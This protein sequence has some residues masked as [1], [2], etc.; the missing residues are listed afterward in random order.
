ML[1]NS[2]RVAFLLAVI[3]TVSSCAPARGTLP[4]A[5]IIG[6]SASFSSAPKIVYWRNGA[7]QRELPYKD[8]AIARNDSAKMLMLANDAIVS[9][10]SGTVIAPSVCRRPALFGF[11]LSPDGD[12]GACLDVSTGSTG[13]DGF[14]SVFSVRPLRLLKRFKYTSFYLNGPHSVTFAS[15]DALWAL[16]R[17]TSCPGGHGRPIYATRLVALEIGTGQMKSGPCTL[18]VPFASGKPLVTR[19][20]AGWEFSGDGGATW[21][22]GRAQA[23]LPGGQVLYVTDAGVLRATGSGEIAKNV[24]DA[25]WAEH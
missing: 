3:A 15:E 12:K 20:S 6:F 11:A 9:E 1:A 13:D 14:I 23:M 24:V 19:V 4:G 25:D 21:Q 7:V 10:P 17:D 16:R 18:T 8:V 22:A 5:L 2:V